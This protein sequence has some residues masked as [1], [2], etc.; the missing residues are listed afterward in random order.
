MTK[1]CFL[2]FS[3]DEWNVDLLLSEIM[4]FN[5]FDFDFKKNCVCIYDAKHPENLLY[6]VEI[7][8]LTMSITIPNRFLSSE[9]EKHF[10]F[11]HSIE[12]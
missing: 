6:S 5:S 1:S 9:S 3:D 11:S 7:D 4:D 10:N 2:L 12:N 8:F